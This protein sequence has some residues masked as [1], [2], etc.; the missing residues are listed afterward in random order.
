MEALK[1]NIYTKIAYGW[2]V[3]LPGGLKYVREYLPENDNIQTYF[4]MLIH[5]PGQKLNATVP[6]IPLTRKS[7]TTV[8]EQLGFMDRKVLP[9]GTPLGLYNLTSSRWIIII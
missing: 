9:S 6:L 2:L 5:G 7:Q 8:P 1:L 4:S 3:S